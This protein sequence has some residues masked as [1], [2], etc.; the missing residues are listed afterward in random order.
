[1]TT[2]ALRT[3]SAPWQGELILACRKCQ[4]KLSAHKH[5]HPL[6]KLKKL[7]KRHNREHPDRPLHVINVPCMDLCP[8]DGVTVCRPARD[9]DLL[10]ILR[11][12]EDLRLLAQSR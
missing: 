1:M 11:N 5:L 2:S 9:P 12:T 6:A 10:S 8:K 3:Y 4:K 7:V